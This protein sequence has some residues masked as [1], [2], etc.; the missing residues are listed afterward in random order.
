MNSNELLI[1]I[2]NKILIKKWILCSQRNCNELI[3]L[4][5]FYNTTSHI[6]IFSKR[7]SLIGKRDH[8]WGHPFFAATIWL[9]YTIMSHDFWRRELCI[10]V[11]IYDMWYDSHPICSA[12]PTHFRDMT[13]VAIFDFASDFLYINEKVKL[14]FQHLLITT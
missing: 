9:F 5:L 10:C 1:K 2:T 3:I 6:D 12:F 7:S 4:N 8:I 14:F 11:N 13:F